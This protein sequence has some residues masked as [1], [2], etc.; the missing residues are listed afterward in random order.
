MSWLPSWRSKPVETITPVMPSLS[1]IA[2]KA[3]KKMSLCSHSA[4]SRAAARVSDNPS[5]KTKL[6]EAAEISKSRPKV[7]TSSLKTEPD[8]TKYDLRQ[9]SQK[10]DDF[11]ALL[12]EKGSALTSVELNLPNDAVFQALVDYCPNLT[13][14][15][16]NT[17][18]MN[19]G[20]IEPT[21]AGLQLVA[22]LK[23]LT[24]F[25]F[26]VDEMFKIDG[27]G[28]SQLLSSDLFVNQLQHLYISLFLL[29][30]DDTIYP[31][32][33]TY[34]QIQTF[35]L[36]GNISKSETLEKY[37]LPPSL[38]KFT[39]VQY[40]YPG[41]IT[42]SFL[43]TL[44]E[45]LTYLSI[46]GSWTNVSA[47]G[48][49]ALQ[50][51]L[52]G[53][54]ELG[55]EGDQLDPT[56]VN[57]ITKPLTSLSLGDCSK[58]ATTDFV[59]ITNNQSNLKSFAIGRAINFNQNVP[60]P[61]TL[62]SLSL[63]APKL[64]TFSALPS[65]LEELTITHINLPYNYYNLSLIKTLRVLRIRK[66]EGFNDG[67]FIPLIDAVKAH[68]QVIELNGINIT[69][70]GAMK[71]AEC[72]KLHTVVL[73]RL[74]AFSADDLSNLLN[75]VNL[76]QRIVNLYIGNLVLNYDNLGPILSN[77]ENLK[78]LFLNL[79]DF[80]LPKNLTLKTQTVG[81]FWLGGSE[82]HK[83]FQLQK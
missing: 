30:V 74:Y 25:R 32:F 31:I 42:D 71:L 35:Y 33:S 14:L 21:N 7:K 53:L 72:P 27:T 59:A 24:S 67:A 2:E 48:L 38:T 23:K 81:S 39:F 58:L 55:L 15:S 65:S 82:F 18:G 69:L 11:I 76:R 12:K 40:P 78:D 36:H 9:G 79:N 26:C 13:T 16:Y 19:I 3:S 60:L 41:L 44:P 62:T 46:S 37:P 57:A 66:C 50:T 29:Y 47:N 68:V 22:Q 56:L 70:K 61:S 73:N 1:I 54:T 51:R 8:L 83:F 52:S 17:P 45:K 20:S 49:S 5:L 43:N 10:P 4:L 63:E 77:I 75:N 6:L 34:K 64:F 80:S 28:I